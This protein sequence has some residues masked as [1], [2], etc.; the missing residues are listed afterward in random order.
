[1]NSTRRSELK[2][3]KRGRGRDISL[4]VS[5]VISFRLSRDGS[6]AEQQGP[7]DTESPRRMRESDTTDRTVI[8]GPVESHHEPNR[9]TT[10]LKRSHLID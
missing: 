9:A 4:G 5:D 7:S 6:T 2:A 8:A 3:K 1:M 10:D